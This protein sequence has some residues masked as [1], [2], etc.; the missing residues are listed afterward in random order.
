MREFILQ[1]THNRPYNAANFKF[2]EFKSKTQTNSRNVDTYR[3]ANK[4]HIN[5]DIEL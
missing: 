2:N 5:Q 4:C 1:C 3:L